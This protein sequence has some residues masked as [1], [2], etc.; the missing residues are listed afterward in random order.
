MRISNLEEYCAVTF[1]KSFP[2]RIEKKFKDQKEGDPNA[3]ISCRVDL[4]RLCYSSAD[5]NKSGIVD[6][7]HA[8]KPECSKKSIERVMKEII[9]KEKRA[10]DLRPVYYAVN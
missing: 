6:E 4:L 9:I 3:I 1:N 7:M 8:L 2:L 10:Q 5:L